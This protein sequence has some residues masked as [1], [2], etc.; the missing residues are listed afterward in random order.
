MPTGRSPA[1]EVDDGSS[2]KQERTE[3]TA[4]LELGNLWGLVS[5]WWLLRNI[6]LELKASGGAADVDPRTQTQ[7]R[8]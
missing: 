2:S 6:D 7:N 5:S 1:G 3:Q 4:K 8:Q